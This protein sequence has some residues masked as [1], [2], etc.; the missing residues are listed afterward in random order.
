MFKKAFFIFL[1]VLLFLIPLFSIC[2]AQTDGNSTFGNLIKVTVQCPPNV[3][4]GTPLDVSVTIYNGAS[5]DLTITKLLVAL[6]GNVGNSS[7][8]IGFFGPFIRDVS[9]TIPSMN[10]SLQ[11]IRIIDKVPASLAGKV[12]TAVVTVTSPD[13]KKEYGTEYCIVDV[14]K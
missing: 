8:G 10:S 3:K 11:T 7:A 12:S 4:V 13:Y 2:F 14:I 1:V 9:W 5:I 6:T